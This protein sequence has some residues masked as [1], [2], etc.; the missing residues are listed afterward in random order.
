METVAADAWASSDPAGAVSLLLQL[1]NPGAA[2]YDV[3]DGLLL[4]REDIRNPLLRARGSAWGG[5]PRRWDAGYAMSPS[6]PWGVELQG[7]EARQLQA[8]SRDPT[9]RPCWNR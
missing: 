6:A 7:A 4:L 8:A 2:D 9:Y 5:W 1:T 3:T